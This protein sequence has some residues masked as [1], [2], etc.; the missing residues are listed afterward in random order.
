[1]NFKTKQ[2]ENLKNHFQETRIPLYNHL[3]NHTFDKR[4]CAVYTLN[5]N[6]PK[7]PEN[8]RKAQNG[9]MFRV[10][11]WRGKKEVGPTERNIYVTRAS[12]TDFNTGVTYYCIRKDIANHL[13]DKTFVVFE[14][15]NFYSE[16][17]NIRDIRNPHNRYGKHILNPQAYMIPGDK[18]SWIPKNLDGKGVPDAFQPKYLSYYPFKYDNNKKE[19]TVNG[20]KYESIKAFCNKI[21]E[22]YEGAKYNTV[23]AFIDRKQNFTI[24][25][26]TF[27]I[28]PEWETVEY[29]IRKTTKVIVVT[30]E[31]V[32]DV[33][34]SSD[35]KTDIKTES[36]IENDFE[37]PLGYR[38]PS[39]K[40]VREYINWDTFGK[41]LE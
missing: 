7:R 39:K 34:V 2:F 5:S 37:N 19:F 33:K 41:D 36:N 27:I 20:K 31:I 8:T 13:D 32:D 22:T 40:P 15:E 26:K 38:L 9:A 10:T 17:F 6:N 3:I 18:L 29:R 35:S 25:N 11:C 21:V 16:P 30:E 14:C 24:G 23:R 28:N 1:M 4:G 12:S